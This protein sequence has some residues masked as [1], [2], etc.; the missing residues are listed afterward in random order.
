MVDQCSLALQALEDT[1]PVVT[2]EPPTKRRRVNGIADR[3]L[4]PCW[5][6]KPI[7]MAVV[8]FEKV[9]KDCRIA[10]FLCWRKD[11]ATARILLWHQ[12]VRKCR[13]QMATTLA[14]VVVTAHCLRSWHHTFTINPDHFIVLSP[15]CN[16]VK[17]SHVRSSLLCF[18]VW[19]ALLLLLT[20][21]FMRVQDDSYVVLRVYDTRLQ[22]STERQPLLYLEATLN[23]KPIGKS[24]LHLKSACGRD[25]RTFGVV[26]KAEDPD[27]LWDGKVNF[28]LCRPASAMECTRHFI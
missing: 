19:S 12:R 17:N 4:P 23:G 14:N 15:H 6:G 18:I 9:P 21:S 2:D 10:V 26:S 11:K 22:S 28:A 20:D 5:D 3:A 16:R 25:R 1:R 13:L 24:F 7:L 27:V 8:T